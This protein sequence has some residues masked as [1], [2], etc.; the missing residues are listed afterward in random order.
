MFENDEDVS[1]WEAVQREEED[2][3]YIY[4]HSGVA[5]VV[6]SIILSITVVVLCGLWLFNKL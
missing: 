3:K 2:I 5:L 6:L 1:F 4:Y